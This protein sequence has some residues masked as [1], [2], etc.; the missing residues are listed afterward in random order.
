MPDTPDPQAPI[1][2]LRSWVA[3]MRPGP[4]DAADT[5]LLA[6]LDQLDPDR[7]ARQSAVVATMLAQ[8]RPVEALASSGILEER[9]L[10]AELSERIIERFLPSV[11][12][13]GSLDTAIARVF[14]QPGDAD[15]LAAIPTATWA[16]LRARLKLEV[17][18]SI[19]I[20]AAL[21]TTMQI[22]AHR[23]A[24]LGLRPALT[25]RVPGLRQENS[26]F[27]ELSGRVLTYL[28]SHGDAIVDNEAELLES[29]LATLDACRSIV[30][31]LR[32][33]KHL[34]GTSLELTALS[35]RMEGL[36]ERLGLLLRL[37]DP[38]A[39]FA[40][41]PLCDLLV[42]LVRAEEQR[43]KLLPLVRQH[44]DLLL[45]QV[46]EHAARTGTHYIAR[47]RTEYWRFLLSSL[48]GGFIVAF[49]ALAK[50]KLAG[51]HLSLAGEALVYSLNYAACFL[52]IYLTGATLAT[53]QPAVTAHTLAAAL[54]RSDGG[55]DIG[56]LAVMVA[57]AWRSQLIS[58]FGNVAAALPTGLVLAAVWRAATGSALANPEKAAHLLHDVH[59][60]AG[61]TAWYAAIA[62]FFLFATGLISGWVDNQLI[63]DGISD[64]IRHHRRLRRVL[65]MR[66]TDRI[67][68]VVD[69]K[70]GALVGNAALGF[71]LGSMGTIGTILGLP[72][73]IRHIAFGS[74]NLAMGLDGLGW[75][76]AASEVL[77]LGLG[78][79]L[80]GLVNLAVSFGL[81]LIIAIQSRSLTLTESRQLALLVFHRLRKRPLDFLY[82]PADDSS[83]PPHAAEGG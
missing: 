24:A 6:F 2:L 5:R 34:Y 82:P 17:D 20:P 22:L 29:C 83:P 33:N 67:A 42:A 3:R 60:W 65:G 18:P 21:S 41:Q 36:I 81:A 52:L 51:L 75:T 45:F 68:A 14:D 28:R 19:A 4:G 26:P 16:R 54:D 71:F 11:P 53:K 7:Q 40:G 70:A 25:S 13:P 46:V 77:I 76:V 73:E 58:L 35:F 43:L 44:T 61:P 69:A 62:G 50:V 15:W 38:Q 48:G 32:A 39:P 59:P 78:V 74:A 49:F 57:R 66:V 1:E 27:V 9:P 8:L 79:G 80:I 23:I 55:R 30:A 47:S 72:L 31:H 10:R 63:Y 12:P 37:T 56:R 64:R